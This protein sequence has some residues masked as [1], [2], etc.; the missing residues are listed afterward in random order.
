MNEIKK[1]LGKIRREVFEFIG[2]D[3]YSRPALNDID[4]KL[5][6]HINFRGGFFIEAGANDGFKQSNTYYLEKNKE[7]TGVLVEPIPALFSKCVKERPNSIVFNCAL[8]PEN[9]EYDNVTMVYAN[10]MSLVKGARK[11]ENKDIDHIVRGISIQKDV[12]DSFEI[13]VP[14][15]TLTSILDEVGERKIDLLSLDVEGYELAV[16][17]GLNFD[18]YQ[19]EYILIE[20]N[21]LEEIDEHLTSYGYKNIDQ[22][23]EHDFLYKNRN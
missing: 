4:R 13:S 7:W 14:G 8:V 3:Y 9:Y 22:F 21:F 12:D 17:Q 5:E 20:A 10:L 6:S 2:L 19:P 11:S 18:K 1:Y 23:S 15:R 16:L